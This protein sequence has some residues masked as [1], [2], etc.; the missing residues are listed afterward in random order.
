MA[1][2]IGLIGCL[3]P[4]HDEAHHWAYE[5]DEG[6]TAWGKLSAEYRTCSIGQ[7]Q[8]PVNI[9]TA[10]S[11][12][13]PLSP[14]IIR[15]HS[16]PST[17]VNNGHTIEDDVGAGDFVNFGNTRFDLEQFHFHHPSE[18][19]L[20]GSHFPLEIHFV[21]RSASAKR[22]ILAV[23]VAEGREHP[24]L[25]TLFDHLPH[26]HEKIRLSADPASLFPEDRQFVEYEGSLTTPPC[27]EGITWVVLTTPISASTAQIGQFAAVFPHNNRPLMPLNGRHLLSSRWP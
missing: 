12:P 9:D 2:C 19:T 8:S 4:G 11:E 20:N 24:L 26:V 25:H 7:H 27:N 22:L 14:V 10:T 3:H 16:T 21:H 13:A 1:A 15:Y 23:F 5:A 18:H 6:P 17:E